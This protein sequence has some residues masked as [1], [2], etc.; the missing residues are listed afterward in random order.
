MMCINICTNCMLVKER[1]RNEEEV[2]Q[3]GTEPKHGIK[4]RRG[5][6]HTEKRKILSHGHCYYP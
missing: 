5:D 6:E 4:R 2:L 1:K 3:Y